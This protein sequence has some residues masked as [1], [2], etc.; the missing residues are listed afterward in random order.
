MIKKVTVGFVVQE[1]NHKGD[2]TAQVFIASD[3]VTYEDDF[4]DKLPPDKHNIAVK[5]ENYQPFDMVQPK[6][7]PI[8]T[9][10][11]KFV[12][13]DCQETRLECC[14]DGPYTSEVLSIDPEGN[15]DYGEINASGEVVRFQC[16]HCE[17]V[18]TGIVDADAEHNFL[19]PYNIINN[20]EIVEWCKENCKQ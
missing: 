2:C 9:D 4:G 8:P 12:C 11:V 3:D 19:S 6:Q 14:E 7:I 20:E 17:Y 5:K 1:Y 16:L 18:L 10:G 15:F 13:P